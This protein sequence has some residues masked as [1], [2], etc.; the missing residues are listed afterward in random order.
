MKSGVMVDFR[1]CCWKSGLLS[2]EMGGT[3]R[4]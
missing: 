4:E 2:S 1:G 3:V